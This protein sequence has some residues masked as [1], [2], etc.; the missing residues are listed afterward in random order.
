MHAVAAC[1]CL[2]CPK[3][4]VGAHVGP[5]HPAYNLYFS[6]CFFSQNSVF[7]SQQIS[8]QYFSAGLSAQP[9]GAI[10]TGASWHHFFY[11]VRLN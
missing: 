5:I 1:N 7:L 9:N 6:A 10:V 3:R 2:L 4:C 8:Q 11:K